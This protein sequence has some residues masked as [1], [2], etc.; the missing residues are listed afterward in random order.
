MGYCSVNAL[1]G[2]HVHSRMRTKTSGAMSLG[3][4]AAFFIHF[5]T[6]RESWTLLTWRL[7]QESKA[8]TRVP[9]GYDGWITAT[10]TVTL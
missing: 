8:N 7:Q 9:C 5:W 1:Y 4:L 6:L 10:Q 3:F 2:Q